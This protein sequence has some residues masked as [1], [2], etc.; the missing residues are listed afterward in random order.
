MSGV[1]DFDKDPELV[2]FVGKIM[3]RTEAFL[4]TKMTFERE[5][6]W[7]L[8]YKETFY[9][10]AVFTTQDGRTAALYAP[11]NRNWDFWCFPV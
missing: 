11:S 9:S 5:S 6:F 4:G 8:N 7:G 10:G 3:I 1:Y 2:R